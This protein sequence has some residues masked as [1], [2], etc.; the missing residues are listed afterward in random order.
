M[1]VANGRSDDSAAFSQ[2]LSAAEAVSADTMHSSSPMTGM[3]DGHS[4]VGRRASDGVVAVG[5]PAHGLLHA[6]SRS[7]QMDG[8]P[9]AAV[10]GHADNERPH[11][12]RKVALACDGCR[13][14]KT[15]CDG[16]RPICGSCKRRSRQPGQ[17]VY[18]TET[19]RASVPDGSIEALHNRIRELETR[20]GSSPSSGRHAPPPN[21]SHSADVTEL[22][23][24]FS[25]GQE[26]PRVPPGR[27]LSVDHII[28]PQW[29]Q[30]AQNG[31]GDYGSHSRPGVATTSNG[32]RPTRSLTMISQPG[33]S[34]TGLNGGA[35]TISENPG[36]NHV[37]SASRRASDD[38]GH[39][40]DRSPTT[41]DLMGAAS[42]TANESDPGA[43]GGRHLFGGSTAASFAKHVVET[44]SWRARDSD[45]HN[46]P[47]STTK[48]TL[49]AA[50]NGV[51]S[52]TKKQS[53]LSMLC[54]ERPGLRLEDFVLPPRR[55]ADHLVSRYWA[56]CATIYPFLHK[57][58]FSL[59]Y[60]KL[61]AT[62]DEN[63]ELVVP[64][65]AGLGNATDG[66]SDT[67]VF[68]CALNAIFAIGC[69]FSDIP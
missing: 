43:V 46:S 3:A 51:S 67:S 66:D 12:R 13:E 36:V 63:I 14:R 52:K 11:K 7:E 60:S 25:P 39:R 31:S 45:D 59:A 62:D 17:C 64:P 18:K 56:V 32:H 26:H 58:T 21:A 27:T 19:M 54:E 8:G 23:S 48:P 34:P 24:L 50:F 53:A 37:R 9:V 20:Y 44:T 49:A 1:A 30:P 5:A 15:R 41:T 29:Q 68:F 40:D 2:L 55:I 57:T 69:Q 4:N 33:P 16:E 35:A 6:S 42:S 28:T 22:R 65:G 61:W 47:R 38:Q 10:N